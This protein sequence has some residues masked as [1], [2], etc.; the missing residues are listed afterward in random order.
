MAQKA[1]QSLPKQHPDWS[2]LKS[3]YRLLSNDA[4]EPWA[5]LEPHQRWVK[6]Q[7]A[8]QPVVL[9]VQDDTHL[10]TRCG[11][12]VQHTSLAVLPDGTCLGVLDARWFLP[13]APPPGETRLQREARWR[14]SC[15]WCEAVRVIGPCPQGVRL[16]HV[17]DRAADDLN[18]MEACEANGGGFVIR[19]RHDR[20]VEDQDKLWSVLGSQTPVGTKAIQIGTQRDSSGKITRQGRQA[21]LTIRRARVQLQP[22]NHHR[23]GV[24]EPRW[25]WAVYLREEDPPEGQEPIDWMLLTSEEVAGLE[26]ALR[27]VEYYRCRW[28][29]EEWH[30]CLK[31]GC[32]IE[33]SQLDEADDHRRLAAILSVVSVRLL[34]LREL[35]ESDRSDEALALQDQ[36]PIT[37]IKIVAKIGK[38]QA[39]TLTPRQFWLTIARQGGY[40]AR[41]RDGRPGWKVIWRGWYDIHQMVRG[42]DLWQELH[43]QQCG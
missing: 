33:Q 10:F 16:I 17:C 19:A 21:T 11:E 8:G 39:A 4:I 32:Q 18:L 37:W 38:L 12:Q 6:R 36:A 26:D 28:L 9:C 24:H 40:P 42:A 20:R 7:M 35:A 27:I 1:G 29:I 2:D 31:E 41:R 43:P 14:E 15:I 25:V 34:N 3:A 30:K 13:V 23:P 5:L 22:P